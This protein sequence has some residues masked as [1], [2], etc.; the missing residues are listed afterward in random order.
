MF[1][2]GD[3]RRS[4]GRV[5]DLEGH[6]LSVLASTR[7]RAGGRCP[8][9]AVSRRSAARWSSRPR[10]P[11]TAGSRAC[12]DQALSYVA[13]AERLSIHDRGV[14]S[15]TRSS[16]GPRTSSRTSSRSGCARCW[17]TGWMVRDDR[18]TGGRSRVASSGGQAGAS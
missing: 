8:S 16:T 4:V 12:A 15:P 3:P 11:Q 18:H 13:V 5:G 7:T 9:T 6:S 17:W 1:A 14:S 10:A 2:G